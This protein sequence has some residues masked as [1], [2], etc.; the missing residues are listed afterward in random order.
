MWNRVKGGFT[1]TPS[2]YNE[3]VREFHSRGCITMMDWLRVY[4]EADVIPFDEAVDKTHKQYYPDEIDMLKDAVSIPGISMTYVLNKALKM[5]KPG[6]PDLYAPGQPCEHK[7]NEE[8]IGCKDCKR[9]RSDCTQC[10]KNKPYKLQRLEWFE[11]L[12]SFSV[13][14]RRLGSLR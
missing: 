7:C 3:F 5:K 13:D 6:D 11:D 12:V 2:E 14:M 10:T 1:I 9:V 4:N 8:C